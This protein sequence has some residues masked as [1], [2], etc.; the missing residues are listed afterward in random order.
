MF[1][2]GFWYAMLP[3]LPLETPADV[4]YICDPAVSTKQRGV[5]VV[6][7]G[8]TV[9][10]SCSKWPKNMV[11]QLVYLVVSDLKTWFYILHIL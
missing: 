1:T 7:P 3:W 6:G 10:I 5:A 2:F 9:C 11:S 4:S 8:I